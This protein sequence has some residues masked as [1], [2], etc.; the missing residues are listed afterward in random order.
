[1]PDAFTVCRVSATADGCGVMCITA[2]P[3]VLQHFA[4]YFSVLGFL[5]GFGLEFYNN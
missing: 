2:P 5:H 4:A 3:V 1:M